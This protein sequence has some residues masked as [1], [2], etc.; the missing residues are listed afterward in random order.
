M[1]Y[2]RLMAF[3]IAFFLMGCSEDSN[4]A[5]VEEIINGEEIEV[6][7]EE[8]E[9]KILAGF[10][11]INY[12]GT[13]EQEREGDAPYLS[14]RIE[15]VQGNTVAVFID[16]MSQGERHIASAA[17]ANVVF[18]DNQAVVVYKD[19]GSGASGEV[20]IELFEDKISL[21]VIMSQ[22]G[23]PIW[24]I[25]EGEFHLVKKQV[26]EEAT[27]PIDDEQAEDSSSTEITG[28]AIEGNPQTDEEYLSIAAEIMAEFETILN[29]M[30]QIYSFGYNNPGDYELVKPHM[31]HL[32]T[33]TFAEKSLKPYV[34]DYY[35]ECDSGLLPGIDEK[36]SNIVIQKTDEETH[37]VIGDFLINPTSPEPDRMVQ[38][39][40]FKKQEHAWNLNDWRYE[41]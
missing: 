36:L 17:Q 23:Q 13:W 16:S 2:K 39:L 27:I 41:N 40:Q 24:R 1:K 30:Y 38:I 9:K 4:E 35:C 29:S 10:R 25:P 18:E 15:N 33:D 37:Q 28:Q 5:E 12:E 34:E 6:K 7:A 26:E 22:E 21:T 8:V 3:G 20:A 31:I 19:D 11:L 32:V 14:T